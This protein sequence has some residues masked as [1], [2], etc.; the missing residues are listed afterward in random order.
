LP[1]GSLLIGPPQAYGTPHIFYDNGVLSFDQSGNGY[2]APF[3][4]LSGEPS[5]DATNITLF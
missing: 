5:I 1:A 4:T 3:A 2:A